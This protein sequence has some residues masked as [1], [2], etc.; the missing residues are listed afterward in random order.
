MDCQHQ[1]SSLHS[2][3]Q[4]HTHSTAVSQ[5]SLLLHSPAQRHNQSLQQHQ[6]SL[7]PLHFTLSSSH[8]QPQAHLLT[9]LDQQPC[10]DSVAHPHSSTPL[11]PH[12]PLGLWPIQPIP[13]LPPGTPSTA[14]NS[15]PSE[16][17][18]T[19]S[20]SCAISTAA[21]ARQPALLET[22]QRVLQR[23]AAKQSDKLGQ[24]GNVAASGLSNTNAT[25]G[26]C[27]TAVGTD[28]VEVTAGVG[29][30][31]QSVGAPHERQQQHQIALIAW[32]GCRRSMQ[33]NL[34]G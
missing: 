1:Q 10:K 16:A 4:L 20:G 27:Q 28:C 34:C 29:G 26:S 21:S 9:S 32:P 22:V 5:P 3:P 19:P 12:I 2:H 6:S 31:S 14:A 13:L 8:P 11:L 17:A 24:A 7:Q 25:A 15:I 30:G 33:F 23:L 18:T